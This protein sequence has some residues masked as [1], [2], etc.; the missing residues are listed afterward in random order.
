MESICNCADSVVGEVEV[1]SGGN[2]SADC[3]DKGS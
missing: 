2:C 1:E 3:V